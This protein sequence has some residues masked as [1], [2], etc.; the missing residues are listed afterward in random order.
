MSRCTLGVLNPRIHALRQIK[1]NNELCIIDSLVRTT[2]CTF[3]VNKHCVINFFKF[4]NFIV[5]PYLKMTHIVC[6]AEACQIKIEQQSERRAWAFWIYWQCCFNRNN[7]VQLVSVFVELS[8]TN[9]TL[10]EYVRQTN[11]VA[12]L[13]GVLATVSQPCIHG[14]PGF[15]YRWEL[16]GFG[17]LYP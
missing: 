15:E 16:R 8:V 10:E 3:F 2:G 1:K 17:P 7:T 13:G 6:S 11:G 14:G 4:I 12:L 9:W 5:F